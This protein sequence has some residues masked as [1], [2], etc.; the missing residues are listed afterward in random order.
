MK[1]QP[2]RMKQATLSRF[3]TPTKNKPKASFSFYTNDEDMVNNGESAGAATKRLKYNEPSPSKMALLTEES[4][5][6]DKPL[7]LGISGDSDAEMQEK[8][9]QKTTELANRSKSAKGQSKLRMSMS[10]GPKLTPLEQQYK[11][12]KA[13]NMD[14]VLAIQVGYKFK[15]FGQDA[16][17][18]S[19][20]LN[21]MLI[22]GNIELD[23]QK[24]DRFAYCLIPDNRL[25]VHLQ[26]LLNNGLKVGV[27]KQTETAAVKS[28]EG[29]NKSGLFERKITGIYT[30]ATYMG[31]ESFTG[32][33]TIN[34]SNN[35]GYVAESTH[36]LCIDETDHP[37]ET[38]LVAVQPVTGS[39]VYDMFSDSFSRD[40]LESRLAYLDPSEVIVIGSSDSPCKETKI[41]L[42]LLNPNIKIYYFQR[43]SLENIHSD[44]VDFFLEIDSSGDCKHLAEYYTLNYP[45]SLQSCL[46]ELIKY[47]AEFKLSSIFTIPAN[48]ICLTNSKLYMTLPINTLRALDI[49]Q[50]QGEPTV[51]K[52]TL[53]WL[54]NHTHTRKGLELLRSWI[55]KPL[56][57]KKNIKNRLDAVWALSNAPF[58]HLLDS[59]KNSLVSLGKNGVDLD[60]NLLKVHYSSTYGTDKISRKDFYTTLKSFADILL[61][62]QEFG[63]KGLEDFHE[64]IPNCELLSSIL[65]SVLES[66]KRDV[67]SDFLKQLNSS[68]AL[69]DKDLTKQKVRFFNI[70][71]YPENFCDI[72]NELNE[73]A[74]VDRLLAEELAEIR[75]LLKRPQLSYVTVLKDTHLIEVRN[76]AM[77]N[78]IPSDWLKIGATKSVSRFRPPKVSSLHKRRLYHTEKLIS[79][80]DESFNRF[81]KEFDSYH[82][83]FREIVQNLATFDCLLSLAK[84]SVSNAS[85]T[86]AEPTFV[87]EQILEIENASHPI[88]LR[89]PSQSPYVPNNVN[90]SYL[91]ERVLI[92]T[93]PNMGGKSSYV[94]Q[95]A[96]LVIMAQIGC[97]LPCVKARMGIFDS[98]YVRMGASDDIL[99]G[100]STFMVE[101]LESARIVK[102]YT[103]KSLV[104]LDEI[105]R[106]TGT[107]DGIAIAH[108]LLKYIIEDKSGPLTLFITHYPSLHVLESEYSNVRNYHMAFIEVARKGD[109]NKEWPEVIFLYKLARGV[110]SNLYGLNVASMA[111]ID[112]SI[113]QTAHE[114]SEKMKSLFESGADLQW[115]SQLNRTDIYHL[116]RSI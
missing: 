24:H 7:T 52:G 104:I 1:R 14:K 39:M 26:R 92:L 41:A 50:V 8:P 42:R 51:K 62:F 5:N 110:V 116:L 66:S 36:V 63:D 82:G 83:Y 71:K 103:E 2:D 79:V 45:L 38:G 15:F 58:V 21:I 109:N 47:L 94:K 88:L 87:E 106:G 68:E 75:T 70:E 40:Q 49:F 19:H 65:K 113:I 23:E 9:I 76:G 18:A 64:K 44:L 27:V 35:L 31:D 59:F 72:Q 101:M 53:L 108:S 34:R 43:K 107:A 80:C 84:A 93:G 55:S 25:H 77:S 95:I 90:L 28:I 29:Q 97:P 54:L 81:L 114:I 33:P 78:L 69:N 56:I 85:V 48:F 13:K 73:I 3:F 100:E 22:N 37:K 11:D 115:Y 4:S 74:T 6:D 61:I 16:V 32:D 20:L 86:Y 12:L 98:I 10:S 57:Q 96:L 89:L 102:E 111:G 46:N 60:R 30:R 112:H 67:V 105:G 17:V 99:K 91:K